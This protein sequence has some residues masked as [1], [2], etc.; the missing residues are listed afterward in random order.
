MGSIYFSALYISQL[1]NLLVCG[2]HVL[3]PFV[4]IVSILCPLTIH[5]L[6]QKMVSYHRSN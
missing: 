6:I 2:H 4:D 5:I 1:S 3:Y